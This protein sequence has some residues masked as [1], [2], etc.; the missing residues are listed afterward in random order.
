M[1]EENFHE[2]KKGLSTILL[3][4]IISLLLQKILAI[5]GLH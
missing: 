5:T 2:V 4:I 3:Q 1:T